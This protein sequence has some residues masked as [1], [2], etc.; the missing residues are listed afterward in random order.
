MPKVI[1]H[2]IKIENGELKI[3]NQGSRIKKIENEKIEI[4]N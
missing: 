1:K 3:E 4:E 2:I